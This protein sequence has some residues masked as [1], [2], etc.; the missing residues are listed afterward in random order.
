MM[1]NVRIRH[2]CCVNLVLYLMGII[3]MPVGVVL[4]IMSGLGAGGYDAWN[5]ALAGLVGQPVSTGIYISSVCVILLTAAVRRRKPRFTTCITSFLLG[6]FTDLWQRICLNSRINELPPYLLFSGGMLIVAFCAAAYMEGDLPPGPTDD[7]VVALHR[8]G[9][10]LGAVK[11]GLDLIC[12]VMA[13]CLGGE[14]GAGT[15]LLTF[16]LGPLIGCFH[17]Y[18]LKAVNKIENRGKYL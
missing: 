16:G 9:L 11:L 6:I 2:S 1:E 8:K 14:I 7:L 17:T 12:A 10:G 4:T 18:I 5:F 3:F 15:V 13:F